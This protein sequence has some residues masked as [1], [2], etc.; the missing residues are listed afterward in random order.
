MFLL[1]DR[2]ENLYECGTHL[3]VRTMARA[4]FKCNSILRIFKAKDGV[5]ATVLLVLHTPLFA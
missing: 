5:N 3:I 1:E 2:E 4:I